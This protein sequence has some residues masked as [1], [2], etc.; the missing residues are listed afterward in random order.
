MTEHKRKLRALSDAEETR[1]QAGIA[2][3]SDNP[4]WTERLQ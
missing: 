4:E 1:I 3:D 2:A